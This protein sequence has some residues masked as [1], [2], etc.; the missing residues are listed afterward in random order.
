VNPKSRRYLIA[1]LLAC[2]LIVASARAQYVEDSIDVGGAWVGGLAYNSR[3]DVIYGASEDGVFFAISCDSNRVIARFPLYGASWVCYDSLDNKAFCTYH[4]YQWNDSLL[5]VDGTTHSRVKAISIPGATIAVWDPVLDRVYVSCQNSAQV[6]VVDARTDSLLTYISVGATPIKLYINTLRQKLYA[7]NSDGGSVSVIDLATNQVIKTVVVG[8]NPNAGYYCR[9]ADKFYSAASFG[10]VAVIDGVGDSVVARIPMPSADD[11]LSMAG[12]EQ[13]AI[14]F[15]GMW[16]GNEGY[17]FA[18]AADADSITYAHDLGL[19]LPQGLLYSTESGYLY[20]A[21]YPN[22]VGV[23]TSDGSRLVKTIPVGGSPFVFA[24]APSH[25]RLYLGHLGTSLLY[26]LKDTAA[27]VSEPG[28]PQAGPRE[29]PTASPNPF[30]HLV[31]IVGDFG[32]CPVRIYS[33]AG[34][35][36]RVVSPVSEGNLRTRAVWDGLNSGGCRVPKGVYLVEVAG[37]R[38]KLVKAR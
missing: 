15:A 23:L 22:S 4:D 25:R 17:L 5:V 28:A 35:L 27:G 7:V 3:E 6:A 34:E 1:G 37:R 38:C 2:C 26:V 19:A 18:I 21:N 9:S 31:S 8:G 29:E 14:V 11:V 10:Y 32:D 16:R 33:P 13:A 24:S 12:N 30:E 20:S 36:V